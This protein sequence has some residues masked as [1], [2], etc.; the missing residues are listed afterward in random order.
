ML[1]LGTRVARVARAQ[2]SGGTI[3]DDRSK[4]AATAG[5]AGDVENCGPSV[6]S[7]EL[8][9]RGAGDNASTAFVQFV[10]FLDLTKNFTVRGRQLR[11]VRSRS[12]IQNSVIC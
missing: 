1:M 5:A 3:Q 10:R 9:D 6:T 4:Q 7:S 8:C 2:G 12:C 11:V